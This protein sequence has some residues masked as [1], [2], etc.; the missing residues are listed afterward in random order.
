MENLALVV[1]SR[2]RFRSYVRPLGGVIGSTGRHVSFRAALRS[3]VSL[4]LTTGL[5]PK[6]DAS[7]GVRDPA[8]TS[9]GNPHKRRM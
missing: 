2:R 9:P 1:Q 4:T 5:L 3:L 6:V 7:R 8:G